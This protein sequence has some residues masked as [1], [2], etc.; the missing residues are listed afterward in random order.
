VYVTLDSYPDSE[1]VSEKETYSDDES[2]DLIGLV[3]SDSNNSVE[4]KK[5]DK[6]SNAYRSGLRIGDL[7]LTIDNEIIADKGDYKDAISQYQ[8]G[9]IIMMKKSRNNR[10]T[11]IAFNIN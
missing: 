2:F 3:V 9:D 5:I 1:Q 4:I 8:K 10:P 7:I 6:K 11:F